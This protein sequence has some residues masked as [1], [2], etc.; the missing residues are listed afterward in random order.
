M[1][2]IPCGQEHLTIEDAIAHARRNLGARTTSAHGV[3]DI[4]P[5]WGTMGS[6]N[7]GW[8]VGYLIT[9]RR[10]WRLDFDP[11]PDKLVHVNEENFDRPRDSQKVIHCVS[12]AKF[13]ADGQ[14]IADDTQ[15]RLYWRKWTSRY[16]FPG[17]GILCPKCRV[18]HAT[19][20]CP[21]P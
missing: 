17:G 9:S 1:S 14:P 5:Y 10:R 7:V 20:R 2:E 11:N 13:N 21:F 6:T 12:A 15:V 18:L 16:G 8:V 3:L 19:G 4:E